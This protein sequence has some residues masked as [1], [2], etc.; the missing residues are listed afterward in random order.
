MDYIK[1]TLPNG[2]RV[3]FVPM[4]D[5]LT[6]TVRV[7]VGAGSEYEEKKNNGISHFLE[8]MCF[9]GT[10]NRPKPM[11]IA[12]ELDAIG[13]SYNAGT[14]RDMTNYYAKAGKQHFEKVFD[15]VTDLYLNSTFPREEIEKERGVII[16]EINMYQDTPMQRID[17]VL[18]AC[19]YGDQPAGWN[20][21]GSKETVRDLSQEDFF[22]YRAKHYCAKN[23]VVIISGNVDVDKTFKMTEATFGSMSANEKEAKR[24]TDNTQNEQQVLVEEKD[25]DQSHMMIGFRAYSVTDERRWALGVLSTALGG[26]MSS[27]LFQRVR[28]ELGAAYYIGSMVET[29][30]DRGFLGIATGANNEKMP[31]VL[32]AILEECRKFVEQPLAEEE[33]HSVIEHITGSMTIHLET[34]DA[35]AR[36][37]GFQ[38]ILTGNVQGPEERIEKYRAITAKDVQEVAV[39]IFR[40]KHLNIGFIGPKQNG[41]SLQSHAKVE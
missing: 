4:K 18:M 8:H 16:E 7:F 41:D 29:S 22:A 11:M 10:T 34:S 12:K 27:R 39:D 23:T 19:M 15:V 36:F 38:E 30:I 31:I 6:T 14:G 26:G 3:I 35:L 28:E 9:K 25:S 32:D 2:L 20:I 40:N 17:D 33:L 13:A 24:E 37:Y 5:S 1:R 21:L